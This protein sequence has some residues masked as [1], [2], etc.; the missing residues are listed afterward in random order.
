MPEGT[1]L[2]PQI[3]ELLET[4]ETLNTT[5]NSINTI[6]HAVERQL[7]EAN[8]GLEVWLDQYDS[9]KLS[10]TTRRDERYTH[11]RSY[12]TEL[13]FAKLGDGWHLARREVVIDTDPQG[14]EVCRESMDGPSPLAQASRKER[15]AALRRLPRLIEALNLEA[16]D[17]ITTIEQAKSLILC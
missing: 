17:A 4:A 13:G 15:I 2:G 10:Q 16:R 12:E 11:P 14:N 5:S 6:L 7:I 1:K 3:L 8:L 9:D